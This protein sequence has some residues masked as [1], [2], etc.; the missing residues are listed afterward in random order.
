MFKKISLIA[1]FAM[2]SFCAQAQEESKESKP[3]K[4]GF[5]AGVI[6]SNFKLK[7]PILLNEDYNVGKY[8][9]GG[10]FLGLTFDTEI[11]E[12]FGFNSELLVAKLDNSHRYLL[13]S[14]LKYRLFNSNFHA[15][16]GLELNYLSSAPDISNGNKGNRAGLNAIFGLEY[17]IN[18]RLSIYSSYSLETTNRFKHDNG[19]SYKGGY[20]N[21]R[22]GIKFKF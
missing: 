22:L 14:S 6:E 9:G 21:V 17:E 15:L 2:L 11:N 13:S 8:E 20:N 16:G 18:D 7:D 1:V 19:N 4:F 10:L 5:T 12:N 3:S